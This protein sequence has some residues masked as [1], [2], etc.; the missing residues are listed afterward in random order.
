MKECDF[1]LLWE[2]R[3]DY[4]ALFGIRSGRVQDGQRKLIS[5]CS[6]LAVKTLFGKG[7]TDVNVPYRLIRSGLLK[8]IVEQMPDDT[9]TPNVII[10]GAVS[11]AGARIYNCPVPHENR[12]TGT[13][14]IVK[15]KLWKA[16]LRAFWQVL[17]CRPKVE[18][19]G[20]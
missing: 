11:A 20:K 18:A 6:R 7:V 3:N 19:L 1:H 17:W 9:L 8:I 15:F 10:S 14:S 2:P 5:A 16:V 4:D 12:K 13:V